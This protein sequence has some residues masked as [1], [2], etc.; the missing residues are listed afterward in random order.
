M[1]DT[2]KQRQ[3]FSIIVSHQGNTLV[4]KAIFLFSSSSSSSLFIIDQ[5]A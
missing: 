3:H 2:Q 5:D 1:I 4:A